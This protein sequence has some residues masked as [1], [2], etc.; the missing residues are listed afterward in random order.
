MAT[1][2]S[3]TWPPFLEPIKLFFKYF[4]Q[5]TVLRGGA[6][7]VFLQVVFGQ[8]KENVHFFGGGEVE[9]LVDCCC[10]MLLD[11]LEGC[12]KNPI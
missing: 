1:S 3:I 6:R 11:A 10:M 8:K 4:F 2:R 7:L 9:G 5:C 12:S